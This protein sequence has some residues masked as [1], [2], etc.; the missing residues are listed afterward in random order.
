M[1]RTFA[2]LILVLCTFLWGI[3]FL[4]Q[5]GAMQHMGPLTFTAIRYFIGAALVAPLAI[6]E[7]RKRILEKMK[8]DSNAEL[9]HYGLK[10]GLVE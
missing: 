4:F 6:S 5:K 3:A 9:I 7:Y 10:H 2:A 1:S 8:L